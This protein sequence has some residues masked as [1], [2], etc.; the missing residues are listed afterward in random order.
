MFLYSLSNESDTNLW[1]A[2][3]LT[4]IKACSHIVA[5]VATI[6]EFAGKSFLHLTPCRLTDWSDLSKIYPFSLMSSIL[7]QGTVQ[8]SQYFGFDFEGVYQ[9]FISKTSPK[10]FHSTFSSI[11]WK[12]SA[13]FLL[14]SVAS[15]LSV[16]SIIFMTLSLSL[17]LS[18][19]S[20]YL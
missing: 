16:L 3:C 18:N 6:I 5:E 4:L 7:N 19:L 2:I 12:T 13:Y 1:F 17:S 8:F 11:F 20:S 14:S 10:L 15:L 9:F